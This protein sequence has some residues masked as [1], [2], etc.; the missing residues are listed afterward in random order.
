MGNISRNS[1]VKIAERPRLV[2]HAM[3]HA[4]SSPIPPS[5]L[6]PLRFPPRFPPPQ[7]LLSCP[8]ASIHSRDSLS[9]VPRAR[10]A[11]PLPIDA[12]ALPGVF[13]CG[14][15]SRKSFG[16]ASYFIQVGALRCRLLLPLFARA[17]GNVMVDCPRYSEHLAETLARMG[18]V[19][20]IVLTHRDDV[21]D[22]A[23]WAA[24]FKAE[25]VLH[26]LE[27]QPD[28]TD[29]EMP[30]DGTGPWC[31]GSD[32]KIIFTPGHTEVSALVQLGEG[33]HGLRW[34]F[35]STSPQWLLSVRSTGGGGFSVELQVEFLLPGVEPH[36]RI[37][38]HPPP[39]PTR[40][41][42][43]RAPRA[44]RL[45]M[46]ERLSIPL[47][48]SAL[49]L[50]SIS[51]LSPHCPPILLPAR[52]TSRLSL[53]PFLLA[54]NPNL[55]FPTT[56][57]RSS[58]PVSP[59]VSTRVPVVPACVPQATGGGSTLRVRRRGMRCCSTLWRGRRRCCCGVTR[60][61]G[62]VGEVHEC[63]CVLVGQQGG[64]G[65]DA[66]A[67]GGG[68]GGAAAAEPLGRGACIAVLVHGLLHE[69]MGRDWMSRVPYLALRDYGMA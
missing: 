28:T 5:S 7:A 22:H 20:Y 61:V 41:S 15:H 29:V 63:A 33:T 8:T 26:A 11:F 10:D 45:G 1:G 66:A 67:R 25:R 43:R 30:L 54:L 9:L 39:P 48:C 42:A 46:G 50:A 2:T 55:H 14:Y 35:R 68:G 60:E 40:R 12:A 65:C 18:G 52:F 36:T 21:A 27:V 16:A 38:S 58:L 4:M 23:R 19:R 69:T 51:F 17:A 37:H 13:H 32:L 34:R 53:P 47:P 6:S 49:N 31:L 57:S 64:E 59:L 24:R 56:P 3:S 62:G 44:G